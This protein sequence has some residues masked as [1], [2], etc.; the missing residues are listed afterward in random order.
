MIIGIDASRANRTHKSGTEW[1]SYYLIKELAKLDKDNQYILYTDEPLSDCLSDLVG[2]DTPANNSK[3]EVKY[4]KD[5]YQIIKSPY[6]NFKAKVL[7][8]PFSNFWTLGRLSIEM[9][10]KKPDVL[11]VPAHGLPLIS[12]RKTVI[13]LHDVAF[14]VDNYIYQKEQL[15]SEKKLGKKIVDVMVKLFTGNKYGANSYDYLDWSTR[16]SLKKANKIITVSEFTKK[17]IE[18]I[19]EYSGDKIE[20]VHNGYCMDIYEKKD[21]QDKED[22]ILEKYG[23]TKPFILNVGRLERKKNTPFLIEGF[24]KAKYF[25]KEMKEKLVL[26]GDASYGYDEVKYMIEEFALD[27]EVVTPGWVE[28]ADMPYIFSAATAFVFPTRHEGFG[29]PVLQA[30]ACGLPVA[31]SDIPVLREVAGDAALFFNNNDKDDIGKAIERVIVEDE[32]R[33]KL[34]SKGMKRAKQYSWKDC[35]RKTL[36]IINSL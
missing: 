9:L 33:E 23:I 13:T 8:W 24:A 19:Y 36:S 5:G 29:I 27:D 3:Q 4:D 20:V 25:N 14:K 6:N 16:Y 21:D 35:A 32:L 10:F 18:R 17:E 11:F 31:C 28:E 15:G 22:D 30:M 2:D 34:I 12:A 1:Y 26:V 7:K